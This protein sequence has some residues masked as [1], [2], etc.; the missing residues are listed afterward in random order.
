VE[1]VERAESDQRCG[2]NH[3]SHQIDVPI[4]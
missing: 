4:R 3:H 2:D 1:H